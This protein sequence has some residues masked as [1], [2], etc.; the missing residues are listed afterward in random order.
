MANQFNWNVI[1]QCRN[2]FEKKR[3]NEIRNEIN[4]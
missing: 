2:P 4:S 3:G 1:D